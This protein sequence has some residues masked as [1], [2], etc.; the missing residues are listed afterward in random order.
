M[1]ASEEIVA[2]APASAIIRPA[3]SHLTSAKPDSPVPHTPHHP[4]PRPP[5]ISLTNSYIPK[6]AACAGPAP[7]ITEA[8]P[9]HNDLIPSVVD[10]ERKC[11]AKE[12]SGAAGRME[13]VD[14]AADEVEVDDAVAEAEARRLEGARTCIRVCGQCRG[15]CC[16][17]R[18]GAGSHTHFDRVDGE[19]NRVFRDTSLGSAMIH[20]RPCSVLALRIKPRKHH[21]RSTNHP[22]PH[23]P[24]QSW[25]KDRA[26]PF[27]GLHSL[28]DSSPNACSHLP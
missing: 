10:I 28:A 4:S 9:R 15:A 23:A 19:D 24:S 3:P 7:M 1:S 14:A 22:P 8:T 18:L 13:A 16:L 26:A 21:H 2:A 6:C 17:D 25:P 5:L 27:D 12:V 11:C 20:W